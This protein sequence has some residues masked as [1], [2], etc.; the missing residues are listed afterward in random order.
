[1]YRLTTDEPEDLIALGPG[2]RPLKEAAKCLRWYIR[3]RIEHDLRSAECG[4][5]TT[6]SS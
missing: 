3:Y 6:S 1:M 5:A 2:P 4:A